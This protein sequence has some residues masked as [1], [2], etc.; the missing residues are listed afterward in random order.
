MRILAVLLFFL[1]PL[2]LMSITKSPTIPTAQPSFEIGGNGRDLKL[3]S[4]VI[5]LENLKI[6]VTEYNELKK[7]N[8]ITNLE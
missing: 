1:I 4:L 8:R 2:G 5:K 7:V 3:D 6:V